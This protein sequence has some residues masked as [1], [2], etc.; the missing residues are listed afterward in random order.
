MRLATKWT[1]SLPPKDKE[2][3]KKRIIASR[4]VLDR[5]KRMLQEELAASHKAAGK[6]DNYSLPAWSEFQ[7][8]KL[9]EQRTLQMVIDLLP[10]D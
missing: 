5:L 7:A 10:K 6:E 9:G 3:F 2:G 1:N 4:D 8:D